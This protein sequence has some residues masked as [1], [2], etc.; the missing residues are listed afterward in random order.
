MHVTIHRKWEN[1]VRPSPP[2]TSMNIQAQ[3]LLCGTEYHTTYFCSLKNNFII[4]I[5]FDILLN[6]ILQ[7]VAEQLF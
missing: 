1:Y 3:A 5:E 7:N 6:M 2:Q 4:K